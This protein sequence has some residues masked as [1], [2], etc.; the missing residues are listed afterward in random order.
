MLISPIEL[1]NRHSVVVKGP[2]LRVV[3][4]VGTCLRSLVFKQ[5]RSR[6]TN[7]R[8]ITFEWNVLKGIWKII[9]TISCAINAFFFLYN[10]V[11]CFPLPYSGP[12][13]TFYS[14]KRHTSTSF[15]T[16]E[17]HS[18]H[19]HDHEQA[20]KQLEERQLPRAGW[21]WAF[22]FLLANKTGIKTSFFKAHWTE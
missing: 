2:P 15:H 11:S 22:G 1:T 6:A 19:L 18:N 3:F 20:S 8:R 10:K 5:L 14:I 9:F 4:L 17:N 7:R 13:Q 16:V 21:W 12:I